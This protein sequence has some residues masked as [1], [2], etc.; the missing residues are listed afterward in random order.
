MPVRF[1]TG[2]SLGFGEGIAVAFA[3]LG[4]AVFATMRDPMRATAR[5]KTY[6]NVVILPLDVTC[7]KSRQNAVDQVLNGQGRIDTLV[8]NA[9]AITRGSIEDTSEISSRHI[10]ERTISALSN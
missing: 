5:L 1:I 2:C 6:Q 4:D 10:F 8:N 9:S 7:S 3:E